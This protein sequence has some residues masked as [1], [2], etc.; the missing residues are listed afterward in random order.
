MRITKRQAYQGHPVPKHVYHVN[1]D[2]TPFDYEILYEPE[3]IYEE[4][5]EPIEEEDE[6]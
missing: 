3:M 2:D 6:E 4:G 1:P 5:T